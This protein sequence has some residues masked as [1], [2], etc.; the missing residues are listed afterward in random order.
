MSEKERKE[1]VRRVY[2]KTTQ[3]KDTVNS[4]RK[5]TVPQK[6]RYECELDHVLEK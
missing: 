2:T 4:E 1:D 6:E 5:P 3:E